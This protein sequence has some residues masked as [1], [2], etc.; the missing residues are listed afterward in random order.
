VIRKL[1][2]SR[3]GVLGL[4]ACA[5]LILA[6][7]SAVALGFTGG[8]G[9][10]S[11]PPARSSG[12]KPVHFVPI[13]SSP[14]PISGRAALRRV[15]AS[16]KRGQMV[17]GHED[18]SD[19]VSARIGTPPRWASTTTAHPA[20]PALYITEK[21]PGTQYGGTIRSLWE[22]DL[23]A[24]AIAELTSESRT[25][26]SAIG[27]A[28]VRVQL[29]DGSVTDTGGAG[30]GD[31]V[32]GQQFAAAHDSD[33]TI[34]RSVERVASMFGLSVESVTIFRPLG[35]APAVV[36]T[37]PD[38]STVASKFRTLE[39]ALFGSR[40][41]YEG[42]YLEIRGNNGKPYVERSASYLTGSGQLW[43]DPSVRG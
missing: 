37:A 9:A 19:L 30:I 2:Q 12:L 18:R 34:K 5:V 27:Y 15:V 25:L 38:I 11:R 36:L 41:R 43:T 42:Y 10:S 7:L 40:P 29:P 1:P 13:G 32:R 31:I 23:L 8:S 21:I 39:D 33:I 35:A 6:S 3:N 17:G 22:A 28:D 4:G 26:R 14:P 24:G 20:V 16:L